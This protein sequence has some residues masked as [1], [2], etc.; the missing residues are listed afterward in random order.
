MRELIHAF[1]NSQYASALR[2][3]DALR[4]SLALDLHLAEHCAPLYAAIRHRALCQYVAPFSSVSLA[5]MATAL[6][7][8]L[9][10]VGVGGRGGR[11]GEGER[12]GSPWGEGGGVRGLQ[13]GWAGGRAGRGGGG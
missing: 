4:P 13:A 2:L 7:T 10:W 5:T 11:G 6:H 1:Y 8:P 3:M 9:G 12:G